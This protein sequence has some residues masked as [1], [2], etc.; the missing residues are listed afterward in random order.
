MKYHMQQSSMTL[1]PDDQPISEAEACDLIW[2][3]LATYAHTRWLHC[4][5][6]I[7][8]P[9][10]DIALP[11][12]LVP[13]MVHCARASTTRASFCPMTQHTPRTQS[14]SAHCNVKVLTPYDNVS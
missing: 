6:I 8:S 11:Q 14:Q 9:Y 13:K 5:K 4:N 1:L 7:V 10:I 2:S 12:T 3:K